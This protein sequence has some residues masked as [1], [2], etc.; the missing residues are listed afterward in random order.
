M[1]QH[2]DHRFAEVGTP[3]GDA[4]IRVTNSDDTIGWILGHGHWFTLVAVH[5][6][7]HCACSDVLVLDVTSFAATHKKVVER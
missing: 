7:D 2:L 3:H 5:L 4:T 1:T 6:S